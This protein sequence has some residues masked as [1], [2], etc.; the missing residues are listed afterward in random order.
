MCVDRG[1]CSVATAVCACVCVPSRCHYRALYDEQ[2][3]LLEKRIAELEQK[4]RNRCGARLFV[5]VVA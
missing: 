4:Y 3:E 1:A 5:V 2:R